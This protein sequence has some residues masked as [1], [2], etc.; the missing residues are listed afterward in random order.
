MLWCSETRT[1]QDM[2]IF[3]LTPGLLSKGEDALTACQL[4]E[5]AALGGIEMHFEHLIAQVRPQIV[6]IAPKIEPLREG[7]GVSLLPCLYR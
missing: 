4:S 5:K 6:V 7:R 3:E 1:G 2:S